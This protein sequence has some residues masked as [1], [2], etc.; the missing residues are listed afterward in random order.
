[1]T[2]IG[3]QNGSLIIHG[4]GNIDQETIDNFVALAGGTA[5]NIVY[6]PTAE[7]D[8]KITATNGSVGEFCGLQAT[9]LHTRDRIEA[10]LDSFVDPIRKATGV[11]IDGGRQPRLAETYL[12]TK[13]QQEL[14]SLLDRGGVIAG[15]SAGATI[16]GSFLV[17]N[18]GAP[19]YVPDL[20]VDPGYPTEGFGFIKNIAIDQHISVRGREIELVG[21]VNSHPGLLGIGIDEDT[22]VLVQSNKITIIGSGNV[23]VH[24]GT[25]PL[26]T[27]G[28]GKSFDLPSRRAV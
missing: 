9:V 21:V 5:A 23:Y 19:A 18:Q 15:T 24:D 11:F 14:A 27:M 8:A 4:G 6:I 10:N 7:E 3:P 22:A 17:R 2:T 25:Y 28:R 13:T 16:L 26:Y 12:N 1:M 20:I